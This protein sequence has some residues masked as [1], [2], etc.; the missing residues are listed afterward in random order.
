[1]ITDRMTSSSV[2][3]IDS[4]APEQDPAE[5]VPAEVVGAEEGAWPGPAADGKVLGERIV[6]WASIG[7]RI[8]TRIHPERGASM[9]RGQ[10]DHGPR[11]DAPPELSVGSP[12]TGAFLA[13]SSPPTLGS[14]RP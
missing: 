12:M 7:A 9:P 14:S 10:R 13:I 5:H 1:M 3:G 6:G 4:R 8:T 11:Y 2:S